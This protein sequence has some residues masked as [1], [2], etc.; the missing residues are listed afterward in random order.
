MVASASQAS[1]AERYAFTPE[2]YAKAAEARRRAAADS[3]E[4]IAAEMQRIA[5]EIARSTK[6]PSAIRVQAIRAVDVMAER[7][8]ILKGEPLPGS[9]KPE[10]RKHDARAKR[11]SMLA[12][13][14]AEAASSA[15]ASSST[16]A[17]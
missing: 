17:A 13:R 4:S 3:Q 2:D 9:L 12:E 16:E 6:E 1:H 5:R 15:D 8:R 11:V 7:L 14:A 10:Q